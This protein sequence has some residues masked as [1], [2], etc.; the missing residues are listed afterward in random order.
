MTRSTSA[1]Y[2]TSAGAILGPE[3]L[4]RIRAERLPMPGALG[5]FSGDT[6]FATDGDSM[7]L[8]PFKMAIWILRASRRPIPGSTSD[9]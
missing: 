8:F 4:A 7:H 1:V 6:D 3:L 2:G 9:D 5:M